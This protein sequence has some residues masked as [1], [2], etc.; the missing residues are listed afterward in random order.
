MIMGEI[1]KGFGLRDKLSQDPL[2]TI[3]GLS[4]LYQGHLNML[5][6]SSYLPLKSVWCYFETISWSIK[7]SQHPI[8]VIFEPL[9]VSPT[10]Y[11]DLSILSRFSI[12]TSEW[13]IIL[14]QPLW[15]LYVSLCVV[16]CSLCIST[17]SQ[18]HSIKYYWLFSKVSSSNAPAL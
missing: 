18:L 17:V 8:N 9:G 11:H 6:H 2:K 3:W 7:L 15:L 14:Y 10:L 13:S 5:A 16:Q 12:F 1:W 4:R